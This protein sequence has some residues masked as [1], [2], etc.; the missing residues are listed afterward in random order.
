MKTDNS[1][2]QSVESFEI[3]KEIEIAAN[4]AV[5]ALSELQPSMRRLY[6]AAVAGGTT[7]RPEQN[8]QVGVMGVA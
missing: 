1:E 3:R 5:Q 8:E 2:R 6:A 7:T 4:D